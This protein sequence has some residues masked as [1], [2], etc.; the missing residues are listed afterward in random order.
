M[1]TTTFA[2]V[3]MSCA[4]CAAKI[5]RQVRSVT[6][7]TTA[8]VNFAA[9][10]L[11]V[12]FDPAHVTIDD[13]ARAVASS[14]NYQLLVPTIEAP[15]DVHDAKAH[16]LRL[17]QQDTILAGILTVLITVGATADMLGLPSFL[18][19][20]R[21]LFV[22]TLPVLCWTGRRFFR[23]AWSAMRHLTADMNTLIAVG[24][25]AAFLFSA[26]A[27]FAPHVFTDGGLTPDLYYDTS[28][29][30]ITFI[31]LGR[32]LEA[33]AKSRTGAAL[34]KLIGLQAKTAVVQR[35]SLHAGGIEEVEVA[36]S[37]VRMGDVIIVRPGQKIP[38]D[39]VIVQGHS[40]VDESMVTGESMPIVKKVGDRVI[41]AT[42]NQT[43][44]FTFRV[45]KISTDTVLA[46][47][48]QLVETAQGSKAPIQR[49]A[50]SI[51]A[52]FV[53]V[54]LVI[55]AGTFVMWYIFGS[56]PAL[57][58]ALVNSVAVLII[59]CPCALGLA[60]PTAIMVGTGKGAE[61]GILIKNATALETAHRV[62]TVVFDKTGTLTTGK[63]TVTDVLLAK[64]IDEKN[65]LPFIAAVE[66]KSEHPLASAIVAYAKKQNLR[67]PIVTNF[68][69]VEGKG[70]IAELHGTRVAVGRYDF[71]IELG[72][73]PLSA[74]LPSAAEL[75][76][77]GKTVVY[78]ALDGRIVM[79]FAV[80]DPVKPAASEV[81]KHLLHLGIHPIMLTGD[82][83]MTALARAHEIGITEVIAE[84]YPGDKAA[85]VKELQARGQIVAMVGDGINDAPALV[86]AD[87]GIAMGTGTD[88]A[89]DSADITLLGG[90]IRR[91]P[92]ALL[93]SR[94]TMRVIKQNL[95]FS[96]LYNTL[97]IPV[98]AGILY[99]FFGILL[100]PMLAAA[101]MALS[102]VS[103][104]SNSLRLK[105]W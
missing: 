59:A 32:L 91:V 82:N 15:I 13:I 14:G 12:T 83:R 79:L 48:I 24:T 76:A 45:E 63:P 99:P 73:E 19:D 104:V 18:A 69:A 42:L 23:D 94:Q 27:T 46:Q 98:A 60:T 49:L 70:V 9:E 80:S 78:A 28:A 71:L 54:V 50:D 56:Q 8:V 39:G 95:F 29:T 6:G 31:L 35:P 88:I 61:R 3:G 40:H 58:F 47:I 84:V 2:I 20:A 52:I 66:E 53:P 25:G 85:K 89:I 74:V 97:G 33:R 51:A 68:R 26:V 30:I 100:S 17:L 57:S 41:G 1:T 105:Y 43:G 16:E 72:A 65:V 36:I 10:K 22:L 11:T 75:Q 67:L 55:A 7:V 64:D 103:V 37:D 38:L 92:E 87:V 44:A 21:L 5:E 4:N 62:T 81:V 96:F 93:L 77:E 34:H 90:D 102:S 101:A 86:Q